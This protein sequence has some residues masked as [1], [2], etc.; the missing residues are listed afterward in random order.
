[1]Q[2]GSHVNSATPGDPPL[3]P[4]RVTIGQGGVVV[5]PDGAVISPPGRAGMLGGGRLSVYQ[6]TVRFTVPLGVNAP[7]RP[8]RG[9][10]VLRLPYQPC[11]DRVC[12]PPE[13]QEVRVP[14]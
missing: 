5:S 12:M 8:G 1:M 2:P 9:D 7:R 11:S 4:T 13:T 14:E 6:G 3:I 10:I